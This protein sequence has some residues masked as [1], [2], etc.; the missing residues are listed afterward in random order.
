MAKRKI[1]FEHRIVKGDRVRVI[2]G[3]FRD[4]EGPVL[5]VH[6]GTQRTSRRGGRQHAEAS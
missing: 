5:R 4:M 1:A 3:N 6:S 2:R